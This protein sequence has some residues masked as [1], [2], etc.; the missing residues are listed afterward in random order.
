M[1]VNLQ[2]LIRFRQNA[3]NLPQVEGLEDACQSM[4]CADP[5]QEPSEFATVAEF[6]DAHSSD[7]GSPFF[8]MPIDELVGHGTVCGAIPNAFTPDF[9]TLLKNHGATTVVFFASF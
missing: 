8:A 2:D 6:V 3:L 4:C 9:V 7:L 1:H 5:G